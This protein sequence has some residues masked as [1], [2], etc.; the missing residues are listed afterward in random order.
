MAKCLGNLDGHVFGRLTVL[1]RGGINEHK[2]IMWECAC[3]CGRVCLVRGDGLRRGST[4]SCGCLQ[5]EMT[6]RRRTTHG[7]CSGEIRTATY[8]TWA[9]MLNRCCNPNHK[10]FYNYGGRGITVCDRWM[11]SFENFLDDMGE[12]PANLTLERKN[13]ESGYSKSNCRWA[14]KTEQSRNRRTAVFIELSGISLMAEE[15]S[16]R[17]GIKVMTIWSRSMRGKS[18]KEILRPFT[19]KRLKCGGNVK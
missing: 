19:T 8:T 4:S 9:S 10:S 5:R 7:H 15:W 16:R 13:N 11:E 14:T 3:L 18:A 2:K 17:L 1:R 6:A 12:R